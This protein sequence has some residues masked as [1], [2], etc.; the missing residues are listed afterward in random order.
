M[1]LNRILHRTPLTVLV[2]LN[3]VTDFLL[4]QWKGF[5]GGE[6]SSHDRRDVV[7]NEH[8]RETICE[9]SLLKTLTAVE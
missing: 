1:A 5:L 7:F 9:I 2:T 8:V 6:G 4:I 3:R